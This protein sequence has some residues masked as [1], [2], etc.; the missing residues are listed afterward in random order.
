MKTLILSFSSNKVDEESYIPHKTGLTFACVNKC[1]AY[2]K[3]KGKEVEHICVNKKYIDRCHICGKGGWGKCW[4]EHQCALKDEFN[5][6]YNYMANFT[7]YIFITPVYFSEMS[8]SAKAFFDRLKRCDVFNENSNIKGKNIICFAC[9]G[10]SGG[11]TTE[12]LNAFALL[13]GFLGTKTMALIPIDKNNF[14]KQTIL[15]EK[16]LDELM[17][18]M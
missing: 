10:G 11:G 6:L 2:I 8:E 7:N 13:S 12:T 1:E 14:I 9:A 16:S 5:E 18:T 3:A 17:E 15:I 4:D